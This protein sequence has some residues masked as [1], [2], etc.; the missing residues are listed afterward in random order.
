MDKNAFFKIGYGLYVVSTND[1]A[2]DNGMINNT[3]MQIT[4]EPYEVVVAV[5]KANYTREL[6]QKTKAF[7]VSVL[8]EDVT[9]DVI[10]RFGFQSGRTA[11]KFDGFESCF[12]MQNGIYAF[13][14]RFANAVFACRVKGETDFSTHTLFIAEVTDS[15]LLSDKST[16]TYDYYQKNVKPK[17]QPQT[18]GKTV[19]RCK[20]CGYEYVGETLPADFICPLCKH[21]ASDFEKVIL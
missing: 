21:P 16:C 3:F 15:V 6:I 7:N 20:I 5:N 17:P 4:N 1:G 12:K 13:N 11:D 14:N 18:A 19:W 9:F 8:S 10:R 2:K